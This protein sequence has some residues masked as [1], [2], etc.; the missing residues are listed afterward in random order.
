MGA[1]EWQKKEIEKETEIEK[2]KDF[3]FGRKLRYILWN[4]KILKY[5]VQE[6]SKEKVFKNDK[7][8]YF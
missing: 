7:K 2:E 6:N 5:F 3:L 1:R 4:L 8:S